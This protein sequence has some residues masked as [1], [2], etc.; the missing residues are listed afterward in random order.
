MVINKKK[1]DAKRKSMGKK[2][3]KLKI[4]QQKKI[5]DPQEL[6][7]RSKKYNQLY[8][9]ILGINT[10][11]LDTGNEVDN[12]EKTVLSMMEKEKVEEE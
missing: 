10:K 9:D 3:K 6:S 8:D 11:I 12:I 5:D 2:P 4:M 7:P 1:E